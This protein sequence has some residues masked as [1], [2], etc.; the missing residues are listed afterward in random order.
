MLYGNVQLSGT[1][2]QT[3]ICGMIY[4]RTCDPGMKGCICTSSTSFCLSVRMHSFPDSWRAMRGAATK[5]RLRPHISWRAPLLPALADYCLPSHQH[6]RRSCMPHARLL[7]VVAPAQPGGRRRCSCPP[8]TTAACSVS[9]TAG[10]QCACVIWRSRGRGAAHVHA[11]PLSMPLLSP[12]HPHMHVCSLCRPPVRPQANPE[13]RVVLW[14]P[15]TRRLAAPRDNN[16]RPSPWANKNAK[17]RQRGHRFHPARRLYRLAS[18][19]AVHNGRGEGSKRSKD[20]AAGAATAGRLRPGEGPLCRAA[21]R[22][23]TR[24][25]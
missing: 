13:G 8:R 15:W 19:W 5:R 9:I 20:A 16:H 14:G 7:P 18:R 23:V 21:L 6:G 12:T 22:L 17:R 4:T 1:K 11:P 3:W 2:Q 25:R 24:P 10:S